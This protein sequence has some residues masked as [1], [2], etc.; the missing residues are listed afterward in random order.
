MK[1]K[2]TTPKQ[3]KSLM[4]EWRLNNYDMSLLLPP[5]MTEE[6]KNEFVSRLDLKVPKKHLQFTFEFGGHFEVPSYGGIQDSFCPG[7]FSN[8]VNAGEFYMLTWEEI[9]DE[10]IAFLELVSI[11][12][13]KGLKAESHA[14]VKN[15]WLSNRWL[16]F[17]A[18]GAGD[19]LCMDFDP[20]ESGAK[21]QV[22]CFLHECPERPKFSN[23]I[24]EF[25]ALLAEEYR[26]ERIYLTDEDYDLRKMRSKDFPSLA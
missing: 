14:D 25:F 16:P 19:F 17:A 23:S 7:N 2:Q 18:N 12:E 24:S 21:G 20:N 10:H 11:E 15:T 1:A 3:F 26:E 13:F 4:S 5:P 8:R 22:I 9:L 6:E